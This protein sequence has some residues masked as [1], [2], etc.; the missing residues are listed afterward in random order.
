MFADEHVTT[1]L[2]ETVTAV[3]G[4]D[5][6]EIA[7]V[8]REFELVRE[9]GG[10]VFFLGSGGGAAHAAHAVN[11]AR[12]L[13]G[14]EAYSPSDN[15]AELTARVNDDGW[16]RS[17][18]DW[19]RVSRLNRNDLVFVFS[20]GGGDAGRGISPNLVRSLEHACAAGAAIC[21][22]VGRATGFT[23]QVATACVTVPVANTARLTPHTEG[24][25]S[26]VWH[27]VISHP[28]LQLQPAR[29]ESIL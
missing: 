17:Y 25:Q 22:V 3:R 5:S 19:L 14:F 6:G 10:R 26:V 4:L 21:G 13:G 18:T 11:D 23:A 12:K 27:L 8:V 1:Y 24:L 20:V 29:W 16:A 7:R 9:R 2:E 15:A 28:A